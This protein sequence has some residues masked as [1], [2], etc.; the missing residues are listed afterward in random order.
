MK[1]FAPV[2]V[3]ERCGGA[4]HV[5]VAAE[6]NNIGRVQGKLGAWSD[7]LERHARARAIAMSMPP[8]MR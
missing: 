6:L 4:G 2:S 5:H 7:A 8:V 3:E 1:S